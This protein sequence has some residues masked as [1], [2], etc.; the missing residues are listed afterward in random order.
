M[1]TNCVNLSVI[2]SEV[3]FFQRGD[4]NGSSVV[5]DHSDDIVSW[6]VVI[7]ELRAVKDTVSFF[8]SP[9]EGFWLLL[10]KKNPRR[11][12]GSTFSF[13]NPLS[14]CIWD[15]SGVGVFLDHGDF[16]VTENIFAQLD[17]ILVSSF[18]WLDKAEVKGFD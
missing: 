18:V 4:W 16:S 8:T 10:V 14:D 7:E 1:S 9:H 13:H 6:A 5:L 12:Q 15:D 2:D 3:S 17:V 11:I